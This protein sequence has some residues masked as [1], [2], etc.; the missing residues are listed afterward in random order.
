MTTR[1]SRYL[2]AIALTGTSLHAQSSATDSVTIHAAAADY[3]EGWFAG[4]SLRMARSLHPELVKRILMR[5]S[6]G[7][8][9]IAQ[10]G[11]TQLIRSTA[12]GFGR[13]T[14]PSAR[15]VIRILDVFN[16]AATVRIDAGAWIDYLQL[17]RWNG[18][19]T[20]LNVLWERR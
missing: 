2:F 19:W 3:I 14:S 15:P 12:T 6:T 17:V 18:R 7:R 16:N 11:A 13:A 20:I 4:D 10:M 9:W 5:D 1:F 8:P